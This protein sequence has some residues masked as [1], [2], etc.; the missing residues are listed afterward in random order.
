VCGAVL[1]VFAFAGPGETDGVQYH[2]VT[3]ERFQEEIANNSFIEWAIYS[4][5]HYGTTVEAV[6]SLKQ[7]KLIAILDIDI[8]GVI[9]LKALPRSRIDPFYI[10]LVPPSIEDLRARLLGRGDT[11]PTSMRKRLDTAVVELE[12]ANKPGYFDRVIVS[13]EREATYKAFVQAM[14]DSQIHDAKM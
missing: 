14:Q 3:K 10:M 13:G 8:Q 1:T 7:R 12:Y 5:N 6:N 4:G 9:S 2:F 11:S